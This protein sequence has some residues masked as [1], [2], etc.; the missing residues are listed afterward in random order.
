[1]RMARILVTVLTVGLA[2]L[3]PIARADDLSQQKQYVLGIDTPS[4]TLLYYSCDQQPYFGGACFT[5]P[6]GSTSV[7]FKILDTT[8]NSPGGFVRFLS[9]G[10]QILSSQAACDDS[11]VVAVPVGTSRVQV[12]VDGPSGASG[13]LSHAAGTTGTITATFRTG[14]GGGGDPA[15]YVPS[16]AVYQVR[17]DK[18]NYVPSGGSMIQADVYRPDAPGTFPVIVWFDVYSKDDP[19]VSSLPA[20]R[21]YFVSRGFVFVEASSPGSNTS[22]GAYDFAFGPAEQ[23]AA[24]DVVEWS[25]LQAWSNGKVAME[26]LSYAAIIEYFA[27]SRRPPHLVT[28]Y[29]TSSYTDLYRNLIYTGG[30][31]QMGYPVAWDAHNRSFAYAP[32]LSVASDPGTEFSNYATTVAGYR[33]LMADIARH[34]YADD[35]YAERSPITYNAQTTVPAAVDVGWHDDMVYGGPINFETLGSSDKRIVIGPWGHSEAHQRPGGREERLR[36]MDHYLKALG[37]GVEQDPRARVFIPLGG[38]D[39]AGH[40]MTSN[41]WPLP[42]TSYVPLYLGGSRSLSDTQ[43]TEAGA[44]SYLFSP[45]RHSAAVQDVSS[46]ESTSFETPALQSSMTVVGYSELDIKAA[47]TAPDTSW[48]VSI[49][50]VSPDGAAKKLQ[51]GWLRAGARALDDSRSAIGRPYQAFDHDEPVPA[52]GFVDY[53][54]PIWPFANEFPAGHRIRVVLSDATAGPGG[55]PAAMPLYPATNTIAFGGVSVSRLLLPVI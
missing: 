4:R 7:R 31:L 44:A 1:M 32:P 46:G 42:G 52:G 51:S 30:N 54:I 26:G 6:A 33:P 55:Y 50:D 47:T 8:P 24:A 41:A 9:L 2:G 3:G 10:G 16:P 12:Y 13:C 17:A 38:R 43:P 39:D 29:P 21:N 5:P 36:W 37:S 20:E 34:P 19:T 25:A 23:Q 14:A 27:A 49:Y 18:K 35:F 11:I 40:W 53:R 28:I 45:T 48:N 15:G 22:G